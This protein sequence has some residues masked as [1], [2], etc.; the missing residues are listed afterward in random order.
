MSS[1]PIEFFTPAHR[2]WLK[3]STISTVALAILMVWMD[4]DLRTSGAPFG[5]VSLQ[6]AGGTQTAKRI[7]NGWSSQ[8]RIVAA[9]GLGLDFL[10][11]ASY[12][13]WLYLGCLWSADRWQWHNEPRSKLIQR[14]AL[15]AIAGA[16]CDVLENIILFDFIHSH[17]KSPAYPVAFWSAVLKFLLCGLALASFAWGLLVPSEKTD[18]AD[19]K[20][21]APEKK[22]EPAKK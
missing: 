2:Y 15:A 7:F 14:A 17:G 9:F 20:K 8:E 22:I 19:T 4:V 13:T 21:P 18:N 12:G 1:G 5:M 10:F 3:I 6:L 16:A 11:I